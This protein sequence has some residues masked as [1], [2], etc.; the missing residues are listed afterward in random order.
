[1]IRTTEQITIIYIFCSFSRFCWK[2]LKCS[3]YGWNSQIILPKPETAELSLKSV[4]Q[5]GK[6]FLQMEERWKNAWLIIKRHLKVQIQHLILHLSRSTTLSSHQLTSRECFWTVGENRGGLCSRPAR[7]SFLK[8][9][10]C[11]TNVYY[12]IYTSVLCKWSTQQ[13]AE[14][15]PVHCLLWENV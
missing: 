15:S 5:S 10:K 7:A 11:I 9:C 13:Y 6:Q 3:W 1:M 14:R 4:E 2:L 8:L 12:I